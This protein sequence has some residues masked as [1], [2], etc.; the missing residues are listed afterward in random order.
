MF[1]DWS[2]LAFK[3]G[4]EDEQTKLDAG[5]AKFQFLYKWVAATTAYENDATVEIVKRLAPLVIIKDD[6]TEEVVAEEIV[7][8]PVV[9]EEVIETEIVEVEI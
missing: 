5:K 8:V 6:N 4:T 1:I 9:V 3:R 2:P 7:T